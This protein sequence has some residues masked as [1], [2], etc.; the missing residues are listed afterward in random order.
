MTAVY[1][2][3]SGGAPLTA[4]IE[5]GEVVGSGAL[6]SHTFGTNTVTIVGGVAPYTQ[7]WS[8]IST[9][10]GSFA[11]SGSDTALTVTPLV[12]GVVASSTASGE[13]LCTVTDAASTVFA[14][15]ASA[16]EYERV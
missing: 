7:V 8:W 10:G 15:T 11:F 9:V 16:Y 1:A 5:P 14:S 3:S 12:T 6:S 2:A 13:L 4:A